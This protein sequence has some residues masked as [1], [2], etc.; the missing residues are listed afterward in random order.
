VR[1]REDRI[2]ASLADI[3]VEVDALYHEALNGLAHIGQPSPSGPPS[4][5]PLAHLLL[6]SKDL[7][8]RLEI[9]T[10]KGPA[11]LKVKD[12]IFLKLKN[13]DRKLVTA[14][15]VWNEE[16]VNIRATKTPAYGLPCDTG[17]IFLSKRELMLTL[18]YQFIISKMSFKMS[19]RSFKSLF[20][21]LPYATCCL[22]S[23]GVAALL[24]S[25]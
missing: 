3:E 21:W 9:I 11:V 23:V 20:S 13:V 17:K 25:A 4:P 24:C 14:K 18:L 2:L 15:M 19:T 12:S 1:S 7:K 5:F 8:S 6:L 16:L 22:V 10:F